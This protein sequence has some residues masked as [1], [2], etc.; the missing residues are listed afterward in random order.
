M[1]RQAT[2]ERW[3]RMLS[4]EKFC[5]YDRISLFLGLAAGWFECPES[6][7]ARFG[8]AAELFRLSTVIVIAHTIMRIQHNPQ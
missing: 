7:V 3:E 1:S 5:S 8:L 6:L 4:I 2:L